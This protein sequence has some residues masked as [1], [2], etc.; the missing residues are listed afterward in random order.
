MTGARL[1]FVV[2]DDSFFVSH[3]LELGLA[4]RDAGLE[5]TVAAAENGG[6]AAIERAGLR[7]VPLSFDRG[8]KSVGRD[9]RTL[10][11]IASLYARIRPRIVH[12]VTIKPVLY[13]SIAARLTGVPAVVNAVSGLGYAFLDRSARGRLLRAAVVRAY[14]LALAHPRCL[15]VFQNDDDRAYFVEHKMLREEQTR[16]VRGSGVDPVRFPQRALPDGIPVVVM[17]ARLR[18]GKGVGE[19]V[20]AAR[21]L[22]CRGVVARFVLVGPADGTNPARVP[23]DQ[24]ER[25]VDEQ[26]VEWWGYRSDMPE[27]LAR[28]HLVVLPS[29]R[30]GLPLALL[31][32]AA[33]G[34]ACVT[35]DV[36]GCRDAIDPGTTGWLVPVRDSHALAQVIEAALADPGELA[37]RG[38][39]GAARA[40]REF[41]RG[42]VADAHL[43]MYRELLG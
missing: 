7:F 31:E 11:T 33:S 4:A 37:G 34:R 30:E 35:T 43:A 29:Y 41:T 10:A 19:F 16:V 2:N 27:V 1:M 20:S 39:A 40:R 22:R 15:T 3:R 32:A 14:R 12:H 13:G 17:P 5:V 28:A 26:V 24:V 36:P 23:R 18:W 25:W 21:E 8:G 9:A 38:A 42:S 6:R